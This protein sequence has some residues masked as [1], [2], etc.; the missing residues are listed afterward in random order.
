LKILNS[1]RF[2][3][4][5]LFTSNYV[6]AQDSLSLFQNLKN[7]YDSERDFKVNI[8]YNPANM[9]DYSSSSFSELYV[10]YYNQK[11]KYIDNKTDQKNKDLV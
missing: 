10:D 9:L 3:L 6:S 4:I 2:L 1:F 11:D 7:Q 8:F 5:I